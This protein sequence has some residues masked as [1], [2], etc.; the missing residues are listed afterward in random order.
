VKK[1]LLLCP[2]LLAFNF[3]PAQIAIKLYQNLDYVKYNIEE[4]IYE[5]EP[6]IY[7]ARTSLAIQFANRDD[8]FHELEFSYAQVA[9]PV[10]HQVFPS[11]EF[12]DVNKDYVG[13]QYELNKVLVKGS[14]F[15]FSLG[16]GTLLY[17]LLTQRDPQTNV[18]VYFREDRYIGAVINLIPR[19]QYNI[20]KQFLV[21]LNLK[22][23]LLDVHYYERRINNPMLPMRQQLQK[24]CETDFLPEAYNVRIGIGYRL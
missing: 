20:S 11:V 17:S 10:V 16:G 13:L 5:Q 3:L 7:F 19:I 12:V 24:S 23:G 6:E 15:R 14:D 18:D 2:G 1:I 4:G 8:L 22:F 9:I 21:D